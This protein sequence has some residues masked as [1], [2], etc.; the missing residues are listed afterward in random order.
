MQVSVPDFYEEEYYSICCDA[1]PLYELCIDSNA[2]IQLG[3]CM[4]CRD[5]STFEVV[6]EIE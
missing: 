6:D 3:V 5:H 1:P 2:N 4:C